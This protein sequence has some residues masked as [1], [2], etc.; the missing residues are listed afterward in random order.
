MFLQSPTPSS[1][2]VFVPSCR[3]G[4]PL[5]PPSC[6]LKNVITFPKASSGD[7][8]QL[9]L[10]WKYLFLR[11]LKLITSLL[12]EGYFGY[13]LST[14]LEDRLTFSISQMPSLSPGTTACDKSLS[15]SLPE[16]DVSFQF[17]L[18]LELFFNV[19]FWERET[20]TEHKWERGREREGHRI[21]SRL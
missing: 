9:L 5:P 11:V 3:S 1:A 2:R 13:V 15:W 12:F 6:G 17:R 21:Q 7:I 16:C 18:L 19:Y 8:L 20:E 10:I 4:M 14:G